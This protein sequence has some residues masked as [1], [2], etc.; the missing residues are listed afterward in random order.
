[1]ASSTAAD[2]LLSLASESS[3]LEPDEI[4]S[5]IADPRW[6]DAGRVHDWRNHVSGALRGLWSELSVE[7]RLVEFLSASAAAAGE[8]WDVLD[9]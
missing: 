1:M 7:S 8:D 4:L 5:A 6:P 3:D 2:R 9:R